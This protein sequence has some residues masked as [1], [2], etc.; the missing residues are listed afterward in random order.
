MQQGIQP[1]DPELKPPS[2]PRT[3]TVDVTHDI[4]V[5][6][7]QK[8]IISCHHTLLALSVILPSIERDIDTNLQAG[9]IKAFK[10][11]WALL[12]QDPWVLQTVQGFHLPLVAQPVQT[13]V[14]SQMHFPPDQ[15]G[16]ISMEVETMLEK[17]A[18]SAVQPNK[19]NFISQLFVIPE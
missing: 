9:R 18:I 15:Q 4:H 6:N 13:T 19:D 7:C 8:V 14:T 12:T 11:N 17:Q 1:I 3:E 2:T 5:V 10:Q 16:L